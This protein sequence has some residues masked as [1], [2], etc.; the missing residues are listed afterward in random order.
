MNTKFNNYLTNI[1]ASESKL[2][3]TDLRD[4][5]QKTIQSSIKGEKNQF[6]DL[7]VDYK[8]IRSKSKDLKSEIK[9]PNMRNKIIHDRAFNS[10][11]TKKSPTV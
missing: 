7:K 2:L 11:Q 10:S 4:F 9:T 8:R 5:K 1:S 6:D 3:I